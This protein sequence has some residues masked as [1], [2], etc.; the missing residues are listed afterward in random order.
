MKPLIIRRILVATDL[1]SDM[2][3][4]VNTARRLSELTD[5]KLHVVHAIENVSDAAT[6]DKRIAEWVAA[7]GGGLEVRVLTGPPGPSITQEAARTEADVIVLGR[8]RNRP[9]KPDGTA[10]RVVRTA[11]VSCLILPTELALPL[12]SV[13]VPVDITEAAR[14]ELNVALSWASALRARTA[15]RKDVSAHIDALHVQ[16]ESR[17]AEDEALRSRLHDVVTAVR[18]R[19]AG[20]AGVSI[21][22]HVAFG[23]VPAAIL[24]AA[25]PPHADLVV[26][27]TRGE[28]IAD[29]PL[30][31]VSSEV[32]K[33]ASGPILLVPPEVWRQNIEPLPS[34]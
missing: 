17:R 28:R 13:L 3:P 21:D 24:A 25:E 7:A 2:F 16:S 18:E 20:I 19:F 14:G 26:L 32:V 33:V 22:E 4:A 23:D 29:D 11:H 10:D 34:M 31:S 15:G 5:A 30:G 1:S 12:R 8:H 9:G 27:G 6:L